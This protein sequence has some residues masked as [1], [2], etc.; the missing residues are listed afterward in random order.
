MQ[1]SSKRAL[2]A[3]L[4]VLCEKPLVTRSDDARLI[5]AASAS[6]GRVVHTVHNWLKA[7]ICS[8]DFGVD[9]RSA[10]VAP[11]WLLATVALACGRFRPLKAAA[12]WRLDPAI[13]GGGILFD[14]GWHALYCIVRWAGVPHGIAAV[15]ETRRFHESPL[16]DTATLSLD[17]ISGTG[18]IYLTWAGEERS[19]SIEIEGEQGRIHAAHDR[20]A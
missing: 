17:L 16:E 10:I 6:A 11:I 19:N 14:H 3:D 12:N 2:G 1:R 4:H 20:V 7:P 9:R 15:L 13:A 18:D 8:Q 5:A